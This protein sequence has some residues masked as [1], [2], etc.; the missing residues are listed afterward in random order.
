MSDFTNSLHLSAAPS[1]PVNMTLCF[2]NKP[3]SHS[4][5]ECLFWANIGSAAMI[6]IFTKLVFFIWIFLTGFSYMLEHFCCAFV[7]GS[8]MLRKIVTEK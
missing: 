5:E 7:P 4:Y 1:A 2:L 8:A 3:C 6:R